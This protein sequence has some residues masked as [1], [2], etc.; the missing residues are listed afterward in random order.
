MRTIVVAML[1]L[2][3]CGKSAQKK[4]EEAWHRTPL[5]QMSA[6]SGGVTYEMRIPEDWTPRQPPDEGWGPT[7]GTAT[8]RPFVTI[9]NVSLSL[10]S[11]LESAVSAAGAAPENVFKKEEKNDN[12]LVVEIKEPS[13]IKATT[14]KR[15]GNT[16]LWCTAEQHNDDGIPFFTE[17]RQQLTRICDSVTP[18]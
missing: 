2:A 13:M 8:K 9:Q 17:T 3:G 18:K 4:Q 10:A 16:F 11:S 5:K 12:Y 6:T 1:L 7:K 15:A 14:F